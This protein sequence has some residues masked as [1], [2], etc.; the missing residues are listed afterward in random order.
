MK[1]AL[2]T[3]D[4]KTVSQHFGR[5]PYYMVFTIEDGKVISSEKRGKAKPDDVDACHPSSRAGFGHGQGCGPDSAAK[6]KDMIGNI[7]DCQVLIARG[8]GL[9]AYQSLKSHGIEPIVN[10][11]KDIDEAVRLYLAGKLENEMDIIC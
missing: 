3:D 7:N 5:A 11:E 4:E 1:I 2:V 10:R 6:H 8:M 9:G